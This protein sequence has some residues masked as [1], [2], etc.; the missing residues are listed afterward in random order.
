MHCA[1]PAPS[2]AAKPKRK[3][4]KEPAVVSVEGEAAARREFVL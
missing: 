3:S 4:T 2:I 1:Q